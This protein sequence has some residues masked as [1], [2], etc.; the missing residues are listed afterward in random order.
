MTPDG[1]PTNHTEMQI[2]DLEE[3]INSLEKAI[4]DLGSS[5]QL[6]QARI[7]I[8]EYKQRINKQILDELDWQSTTTILK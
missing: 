7:E 3:Y 6:I 8:L 5:I 2:E 4:S 1:E